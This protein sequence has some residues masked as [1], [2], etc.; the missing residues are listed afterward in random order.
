[1]A[2]F[3]GKNSKQAIYIFS[4]DYGFKNIFSEIF[5]FFT[6]YKIFKEHHGVRSFIFTLV[7]NFHPF[8]EHIHNLHIAKYTGYTETSL[9]VARTVYIACF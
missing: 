7:F 1:M 3:F 8:L 9:I 5:M 2:P 6:S 4:T